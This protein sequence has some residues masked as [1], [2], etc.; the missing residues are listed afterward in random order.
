MD[1]Q[2]AQSNLTNFANNM[3]SPT[4][5]LNSAQSQ[6]GVNQAG[7]TVQGLQG[8][9]NST[10]NLLNQV[11][12]SVMGRT[13]Q[14]LVTSDQAKGEIANEQQPLNQQLTSDQNLYGQANSNYQN[15]ENQATTQASLVNTGNQNQLSYLE[16]VYND[17]AQNEAS[18]SSLQEQ[19][20]EFNA[21]MGAGVSI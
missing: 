8:A 13:G 3:Q 9:I 1:S 2:Q 7:Q 11:A 5:A 14:S 4:A 20:N 16:S 18:Q 15:A 6:L 19:E 12:P 21:E 17:I 10:S